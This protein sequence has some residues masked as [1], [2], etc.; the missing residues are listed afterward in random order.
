MAKGYRLIDRDR[1]YKALQGR[2]RR[3]R[4]TKPAVE[5]GVLGDA[6]REKHRGS[7]EGSPVRLSDVASWQEFGL[8]RIPER[9]FIRGWFDA[10]YQGN[11]LALRTVM[12]KVLQGHLTE[13][14]GMELL[15]VKFQADIQ[16]RIS[17]GIPPPNS[18]VTIALKGSAIPLIDKGQLLQGITF[19][20]TE[21]K[22]A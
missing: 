21:R 2:L 13:K 14:Q 17:R 5:V 1:G 18:E 7:D 3:V 20:A 15:G 9:S 16:K 8:G 11:R 4:Q 19:R 22:V 12:Q 6:A 10:Q